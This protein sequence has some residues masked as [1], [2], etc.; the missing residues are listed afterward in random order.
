MVLSKLIQWDE[1]QGLTVYNTLTLLV[2]PP[3]KHCY[4]YKAHNRDGSDV[5]TSLP[6]LGRF[7]LQLFGLLSPNAAVIIKKY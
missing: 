5:L 2:L 7:L 1:N 6:Q 3:L 4:Q